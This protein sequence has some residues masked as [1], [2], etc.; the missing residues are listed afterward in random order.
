MTNRSLAQR[1]FSFPTMLGGALLLTLFLLASSP[2]RS[3]RALSDP[4]IWWHLANAKYLVTTHHFIRQDFYSFTLSGTRWLNIEWLAEL[5]YYFA[6]HA[7]SYTGLYLMTMVLASAIVLGT[8]WLAWLRTGD[9]KASFATGWI[10]VFFASVS[11][12]PRM[13]LFGWLLL[14]VQLLIEQLFRKGRDYTWAMPVVFAL[15][16]NLHGSWMIGFVLWLVWV[17]SGFVRG[18]WGAV[19]AIPWTPQQRKKLLIV[20]AVSLAA[21]LLNPYGWRLVA[22][23]FDMAFAQAENLKQIAEWATIDFHGLRGKFV[24]GVLFLMVVLNLVR[25]R[26]WPLSELLM[27][28]IVVYSGLTYSR[29][30]FMAGIVLA[31]M[32]AVD[33][34]WGVRWLLGGYDPK[35]DGVGRNVAALAVLGA[36]IVYT[37]PPV[38][39][40]HVGAMDSFPEQALP[41]LAQ[42]PASARIFNHY[43]WGGFMI[44]N[45]PQHH[46]FVDSRTDIFVHAGTLTDYASAVTPFHSLEVLDKYHIDYVFIPH[47]TAMAYLLEQSA[48]W[49]VDYKDDLTVIFRRTTVAKP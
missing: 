46:T 11:L 42:I 15:W 18:R 12:A 22:Y 31:P 20:T 32:L 6:F 48:G 19:V 30:L 23:P 25:R 14:V 26:R 40:M 37:I 33:L 3:G 13:L 36:V 9:V 44:W 35:T 29:F 39:A 21:L 43:E 2:N 1:I 5:P 4:D 24:M 7:F 17:G 10:A 49:T 8:Y 38:A 34:G 47:E 45:Q 28:L 16:I 27:A 41:R